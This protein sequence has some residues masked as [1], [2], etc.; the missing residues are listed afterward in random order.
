MLP[1]RHPLVSG[2]GDAA[3]AAPRAAGAAGLGWSC[4]RAGSGRLRGAGAAAAV[5]PLALITQ[6][7][8]AC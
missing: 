3:G 4:G 6:V 7:K 5:S 8:M 2:S 1:A